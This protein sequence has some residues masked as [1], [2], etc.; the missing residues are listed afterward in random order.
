MANINII[1]MLIEQGGR[2]ASEIIRIRPRRQAV[3]AQQTQPFEPISSAEPSPSPAPQASSSPSEPSPEP[4]A[5]V[6]EKIAPEK[7]TAVDTGCV[8]C[9]L[10]HIGTCSGLLNESMRFANKE[11]M[12]DE[13]VDRINMCLDELNTMERVDLRPEMV[14]NL[15]GWE[16]D[17]ATEALTQ[18]RTIRH[19]LEGVRTKEGLNSLAAETQKARRALGRKYFAAKMYSMPDVT[20]E[21]KARILAKFDAEADRQDDNQN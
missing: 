18:S 14:E 11:G 12:T 8:P 2:L 20:D 13:V 5:Q 16:K 19:G 9:S 7:A 21:Q 4:K 3:S 10:G 17:L 6:K 1:A 15:T